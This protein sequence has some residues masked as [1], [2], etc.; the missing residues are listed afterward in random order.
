MYS[1]EPLD[2]TS[3]NVVSYLTFNINH[4][5]SSVS[6]AY[7]HLSAI[8]YYYRINGKVSITESTIVTMFMKGLKRRNL[9]HV[10]KRATPMSTEVLSDM[11]KLLDDGPTLVVWRT[12]WRAHIAFGLMLRFDDLKR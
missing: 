8:A 12:V 11:R 2:C 7:T 6:L 3:Q 4:G 10:V 9:N 1:L 5:S